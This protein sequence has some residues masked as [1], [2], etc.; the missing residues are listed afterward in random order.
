MRV[1]TTIWLSQYARVNYW[2]AW[3]RWH[4]EQ[5]WDFVTDEWDRILTYLPDN[6]IGRMLGGVRWLEHADPDD[7]H[8]FLDQHEVPQA[9]LAVAQ[10]RER[11]DVHVALRDRLADEMTRLSSDA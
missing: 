11:L 10:H 1:P 3:A 5:V 6:T 8:A 9:K 2:P 7:V 4:G